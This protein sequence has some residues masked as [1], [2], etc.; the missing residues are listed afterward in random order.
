[1]KAFAMTSPNNVGWID[2]EYPKAGPYDAIVRT[3]AISPCT[4][5]VHI[6]YEDALGAM[7]NV[8]L[9]HE[10]VGEIVEV[11]SEVEVFKVG[12]RVLVGAI[13]PDWRSIEAQAGFPQHSGGSMG[14]YKFTVQ[15]PGSFA[16]FF[17]VNDVDMNAA[18]I[19]DE[20]SLE[21]AV[22][23]TDMVTTGFHGAENA[24]IEIGNTVAILGIGAVGLMALAGA[25]LRGAGRIFAVG[26]R[27]VC[28]EAAKYYG[29]TDI[30]NYKEGDIV[31]QIMDLTNGK[32]V[33]RV[34][35]AGGKEDIIAQGINMV[36]TGGVV[37]NINFFSEVDNIPIPRVGW[38]S[39]MSN[40]K[41][42]GGLCPGGRRRLEMIVDLVKYN[43]IDPKRL[44]THTFN[45][46]DKIE[47]AFLM[48]KDKPKDLIKPIVLIGK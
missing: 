46:I 26:S 35:T 10:A 11:G 32:G 1:M 34:I 41:I 39:G 43:R 28:V 48:M 16:E 8:V 38:A 7:E 12:D 40:K 36:K 22:M 33:D 14:G 24:D 9:G 23:I 3:L 31:Q 45:G 21:E 6:V 29:A 4:S 42:I 25:K 15:K 17:H 19:P 13:T 20:M 30:V 27:P 18:L 47:E 37:S 5:D 44:V 2:I